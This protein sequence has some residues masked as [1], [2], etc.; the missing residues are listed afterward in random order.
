MLIAS[1]LQRRDAKDQ[2][3]DDERTQLRDDVKR[4]RSWAARSPTDSRRESEG[5]AR[6]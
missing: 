1:W 5:R 3:R 4:R 6:R 2:R